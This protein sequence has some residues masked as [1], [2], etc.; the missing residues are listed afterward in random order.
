[1]V[2][3]IALDGLTESRILLDC[4]TARGRRTRVDDATL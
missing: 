1:M 3:G 2:S 4:A